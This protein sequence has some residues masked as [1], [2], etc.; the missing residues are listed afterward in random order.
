MKFIETNAYLCILEVFRSGSHPGR[1]LGKPVELQQ[2]CKWDENEALEL[3]DMHPSPGAVLGQHATGER[4][5]LLLGMCPKAYLMQRVRRMHPSLTAGQSPQYFIT[6]TS[7]PDSHCQQVVTLTWRF[8]AE[9]SLNLSPRI[10][11]QR[12]RRNSRFS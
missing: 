9:T 5:F 3:P 10:Y 8:Q 2:G 4:D 12:L 7:I 6:T 11:I 1:S